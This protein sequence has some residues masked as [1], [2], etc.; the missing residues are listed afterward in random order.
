MH[1]KFNF[2]FF[3]PFIQRTKK[4]HSSQVKMGNENTSYHSVFVW[5][6]WLLCMCQRKK[7]G[8]RSHEHAQ[9]KANKNW[10]WTCVAHRV[11]HAMSPSIRV[12][13]RRA[14]NYKISTCIMCTISVRHLFRMDCSYS[15]F[16]SLQFR[17]FHVVSCVPFFVNEP[18]LFGYIRSWT[19]SKTPTICMYR[20]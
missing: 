14:Q 13:P 17:M 15:H 8:T 18:K 20:I 3:S 4:A 1:G 2:V 7:T 9:I 19:L 5:C 11:G 16:L 10:V 6:W 12:V